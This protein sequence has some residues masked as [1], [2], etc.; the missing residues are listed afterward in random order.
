MSRSRPPALPPDRPAAP[1]AA[2]E[3]LLEGE[4]DNPGQYLL[5]RALWLDALDRQIRS[6]LPPTLAA[7]LRLGNVDRGRLVVLVESPVW[8]ARVRLA[9]T[10][11]LDAARSIGLEVH[12][13]AVKTKTGPSPLRPNDT[14]A[15]QSPMKPLSAAAQEAMRAALD[16]GGGEPQ[17]DS[18]S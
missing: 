5:R 1:Q 18:E 13:L 4:A 10:E 16:A 12:E 3:A 9:A 11:V 2:V 14:A 17:P 8:H 6:L 7:H 15:M